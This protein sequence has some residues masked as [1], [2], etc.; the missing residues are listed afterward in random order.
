MKSS[1]LYFSKD[2]DLSIIQ[3]K[4]VGVIGY[5]SQGRAQA[6]NLIDSNVNVVI[7]LRDGSDKIKELQ[8]KNISYD[9]ISN[10]VKSVDVIVLLV[11]DKIMKNVYNDSIRKHLK[12]GQTIIF[13]HGYNI[14]YNL[15]NIPDFVNVVMIAPSGGGDVV[16]NEY[17]KKSGVPAL[18]AV[19]NDYSG[20]T[21]DLIKSYGLA[22]GSS[23]IC[24]F[25][26]TF[27]EE[28][29]TDL[30]GEQVVLTGGI[31]FY[32]NKSIKVLLDAG[33]SPEVAWFVCYYELKTIID[34]FH[35]KGLNYLYK[36]ISKTAKYGGITRGEYLIDDSIEKKMKKVLNDIQSGT[37][38]D[39][40]IK[41]K[42]KEYKSPFS[43]ENNDLFN[44]LIST[45]FSEK[46]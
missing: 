6:L 7:G 44:H 37:F 13:S 20:C 22:I 16:R 24:L 11:P 15:I 27:K 17:K 10:V 42:E 35:K 9:N 21:I 33:Y 12:K 4:T 36:S 40:L 41:S 39:E 38:H 34:L 28:T 19:N 5:G 45:L 30:F 46:K 3:N 8:Q 23:R 1:K 18:I 43:E 25:V 2:C 32:I 26:S 29:E 14:H 31:P